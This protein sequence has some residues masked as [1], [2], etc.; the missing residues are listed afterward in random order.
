MGDTWVIDLR[1]YL[2][3]D[4]SLADMPAEA[5]NLAMF[6]G[7]IA[8]WVTRSP[9]FES[10]LTN[11]RCRRSPKRSRCIGEIVARLD[12]QTMHIVWGCPLCGDNGLIHGWQETYWDRRISGNHSVH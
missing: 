10:E 9:D 3:E 8:A 1:H 6:F 5:T 2:D 7:S 12:T 11:V 4:G